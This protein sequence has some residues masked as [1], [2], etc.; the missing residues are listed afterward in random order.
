[1]VQKRT[2]QVAVQ[3]FLRIIG[4]D[5]ML[6]EE[7]LKDDLAKYITHKYQKLNCCVL[8]QKSL[9]DKKMQLILKKHNVQP[10]N[11]SIFSVI[12]RH[13]SIS[14]SVGYSKMPTIIFS[15]ADDKKGD[16][17]VPLSNITPKKFSYY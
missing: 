12:I 10:T 17:R 4:V 8:S 5:P 2:K 9:N 15:E 16:E 14:A 1:M 13:S 6:A 7:A 3:E 11:N